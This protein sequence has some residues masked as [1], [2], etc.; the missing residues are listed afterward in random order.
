M[1]AGVAPPRSSASVTEAGLLGPGGGGQG[2]GDSS[3]AVA[4]FTVGTLVTSQAVHRLNW[5]CLQFAAC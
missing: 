4:P 1:C 5:Q 2:W 3:G